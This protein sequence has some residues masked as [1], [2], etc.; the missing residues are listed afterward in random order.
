MRGVSSRAFIVNSA[1]SGADAQRT[2]NASRKSV[3][4]TKPVILSWISCPFENL[5]A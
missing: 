3:D 1:Y 2:S 5:L 4:Y